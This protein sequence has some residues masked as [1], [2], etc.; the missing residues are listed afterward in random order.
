[1]KKRML[2]R[3]S[4]LVS[5]LRRVWL[6]LGSILG[7]LGDH[8]GDLGGSFGGVFGVRS[9]KVAPRGSPEPI[10]EGLGSILEGLGSHLASILRVLGAI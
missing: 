10:W 8:L 7:G 6:D 3:E 2:N 4:C 9:A 5:F 1:M